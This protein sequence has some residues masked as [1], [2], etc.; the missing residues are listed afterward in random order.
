MVGSVCRRMA[1][2]AHLRLEEASYSLP[3][4]VIDEKKGIYDDEVTK[5]D[6]FGKRV[7]ENDDCMGSRRRREGGV[8][9]TKVWFLV[10]W[11]RSKS[12]IEPCR[13]DLFRSC[14]RQTEKP[15]TR[16]VYTHGSRCAR[17]K[18]VEFRQG[19]ASL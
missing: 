16:H 10:I 17:A 14:S 9:E 4:A 8:E 19:E 15:S 12:R 18:D 2:D 11:S 13:S 6:C 1:G 7:D 5:E 3:S